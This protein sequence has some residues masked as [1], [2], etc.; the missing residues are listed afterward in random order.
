MPLPK[1]EDD[2]KEDEFIARC[3]SNDTMVEDYSDEEQRLAICFSQWRKEEEGKFMGIERKTLSFEIKGIDEETGI[4][5]GYAAT[6]AKRPDSYGD[7]ID[8]GAFK[9]TL[10]EGGKR[11]KILWNHNTMEPIGRPE[12]M[13]EDENGLHVKGKLSLGV[14]RAREVLALMKDGVITEMS[15]GYDAV[16]EAWEKGIRHLKE[17]KLWD[18]SPVTFAANPEASITGVKA[19]LNRLLKSGRVL[20]ASNVG[21]VQSAINALQALLDLA[22]GDEE[23]DKSTPME[24][25]QD[26]PEPEEVKEAV[27]LEAILNDIGAAIDGFDVKQAE[28]RIDQILEKIN[29]EVKTNA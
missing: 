15:I 16:T 7:I 22:E 11:V 27:E 1:P 2:E 18:I 25:S 13:T 4:F 29:M 21:K 28:A 8:S 10:K 17:I 3:M 14:Q 5:E 26:T 20:S 23:P 6:F 19:E 9:K 12:K 24:P